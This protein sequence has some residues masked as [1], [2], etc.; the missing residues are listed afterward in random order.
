M[1]CEYQEFLGFGNKSLLRVVNGSQISPRYVINIEKIYG[2]R[3][4]L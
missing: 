2:L 4:K 1:R 3:D